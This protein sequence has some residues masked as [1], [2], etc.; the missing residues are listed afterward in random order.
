[1]P[2]LEEIAGHLAGL[3]QVLAR[4]ADAVTPPHRDRQAEPDAGQ[5]RGGARD[6]SG[7][8]ARDRE[9]TA[10]LPP[11]L[12]RPEEVG[13]AEAAEILGVSKDTVLAYR[14]KGLLPSRNLAPPGSSRPIFMFPLADVMKL[15][16]GYDFEG[17]D[18]TPRPETT[19]RRGKGRCKFELLDLD[20]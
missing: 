8:R 4:I 2:Q 6:R 17:P 18:D 14:E 5:G 16:T 10:G 19:R 3:V 7:R 13:T 11:G 9:G 12:S 15:R 1:V 20:D